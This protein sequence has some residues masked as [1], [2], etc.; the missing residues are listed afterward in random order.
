MNTFFNIFLLTSVFSIIG[1]IDYKDYVV[2]KPDVEVFDLDGSEEFLVIA[3]DGLWD[4][5]DAEDAAG[6]VRE[7]VAES[8]GKLTCFHVLTLF[9]D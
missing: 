2:S 6:I 8:N 3:C 9:I 7:T 4:E 5:M 1:D